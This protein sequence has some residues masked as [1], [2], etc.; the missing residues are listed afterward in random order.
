M[1]FETNGL[2]ALYFQPVETQALSTRGQP[3][4]IQAL[5]TRGQPDISTCTALPRLRSFVSIAPLS[6]LSIGV[7]LPAASPTFSSSNASGV[8]EAASLRPSRL[9][10]S[11]AGLSS[12]LVAVEDEV[13]P[14]A[15][16]PRSTTLLSSEGTPAHA[17]LRPPRPWRRAA[18]EGNALWHDTRLRAGSMRTTADTPPAGGA[19]RR[20]VAGVDAC[21]KK[22]DGFAARGRTCGAICP[23]P[24]RILGTPR[25]Y[26]SRRYATR[27]RRLH[28]FNRTKRRRSM[29][30]MCP[31]YTMLYSEH[32][33]EHL[34]QAP[35]DVC[36][37]LS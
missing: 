35:A 7:E 14:P 24:K 10:T 5:S 4:K 15:S 6:D 12:Q 27:T 22:C 19:R 16:L 21:L 30:E 36:K 34:S 37:L 8:G 2:K 1:I 32:F 23:M 31:R 3:V 25:V 28:F 26:R 18:A 33:T 29:F 9:F 13:A 17:T 11:S 20:R